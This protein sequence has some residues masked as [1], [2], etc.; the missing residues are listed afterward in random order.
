M[1]RE[2]LAAAIAELAARGY[3][4]LRIEDVAERAGVNKTTV[5][6]R[7]PTKGEL[8]AAAVHAA[9]PSED[10][11][12]DTG[13]LRRDL[14]EHIKRILRWIRTDEGRAIMRLITTERGDPHIE[15]L[16]R[17]LRKEAL[18]K[19]VALVEHAIA[20]GELAPDTDGALLVEAVVAPI[21]SRVIRFEER[22]DDA[23]IAAFADLVVTGAEHGGAKRRS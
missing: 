12:P 11:L 19:R 9:K 4:A 1:V 22:V 21:M 17:A 18:A 16:A 23:T 13:D 6:R 7:W 3:A 5:Y 10:L 2:V 8:L 14:V 20:R 15:G